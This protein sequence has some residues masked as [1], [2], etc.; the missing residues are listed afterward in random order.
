MENIDVYLDNCRKM[1]SKDLSEATG[2][3]FKKFV[4]Y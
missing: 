1:V 4:P 2:Q 3:Q